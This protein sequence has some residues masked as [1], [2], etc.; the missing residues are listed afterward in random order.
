MPIK[1]LGNQYWTANLVVLD[2]TGEASAPNAIHAMYEDQQREMEAA[3]SYA[4]SAIDAG[5][6]AK[7]TQAQ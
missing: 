4:I 5:R 6:F 3:L 2:G 1:L 7:P